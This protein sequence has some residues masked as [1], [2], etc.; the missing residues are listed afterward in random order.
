MGEVMT[1]NLSGKV[2]RKASSNPKKEKLRKTKKA[3]ATT[4]IRKD[5]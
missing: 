1:Y 4:I 5:K 2:K 3:Q